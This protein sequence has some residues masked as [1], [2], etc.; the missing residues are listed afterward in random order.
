[1][2]PL[3]AQYMSDHKI[4]VFYPDDKLKKIRQMARYEKYSTRKGAIMVWVDACPEN[5]SVD[6]FGAYLDVNQIV[7]GKMHHTNVSFQEAIDH[8]EKSLGI[9]N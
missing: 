9:E 2:S 3:A 1:M 6:G 5:T 7:N 8:I 4:Y